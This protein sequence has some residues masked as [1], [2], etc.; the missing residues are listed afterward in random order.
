MTECPARTLRRNPFP[1]IASSKP[2]WIPQ[3][4]IAHGPAD[5][6]V[7][8]QRSRDLLAALTKAGAAATLTVLPARATRNQRSCA[9]SEADARVP[10]PR[11]PH[12]T[13][14]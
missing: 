6:V 2:G 9:R 13:A 3:F 5:C 1:Y 11:L 12:V 4:R 14:L 7:P 10:R 8:V